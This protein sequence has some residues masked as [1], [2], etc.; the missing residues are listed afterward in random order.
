[1]RLN[2]HSFQVLN[3]EITGHYYNLKAMIL[4]STGISEAL[5]ITKITVQTFLSLQTAASK[6]K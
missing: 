4:N 1:M 3:T 2:C 5:S 6:C